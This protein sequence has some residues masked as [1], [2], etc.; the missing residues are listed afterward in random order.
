MMK[1]M[2][3]TE[4]KKNIPETE[5]TEKKKEV[6]AD[7]MKKAAGGGVIDSVAD[8]LNH[9]ACLVGAHVV[10]TKSACYYLDGVWHSKYRCELCGK[11][12]YEKQA[13][14]DLMGHSITK[15]EFD[16]NWLK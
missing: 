1:N 9:K 13:D 12:W 16:R 4:D 6:T 15:A 3:D 14:G 7:E 10:N 2:K 5:R 11:V 8:W